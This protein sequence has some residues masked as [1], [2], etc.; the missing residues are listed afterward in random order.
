VIPHEYIPGVEKGVQSVWDSGELIGFPFFDTR[1]TL[2]DG[3]YH[4][5]DSSAFAFETAAREAM[6]DDVVRASLKIMEPIM[7]VEVL[8]PTDFVGSVVADLN[9]R[10]SHI[11]GQARRCEPTPPC[12]A[13]M[14]RWLGCLATKGT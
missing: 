4:D 1:V 8:S 9:N 6:R 13:P 5:M 14:R 2:F 7:D 12:S 11:R 3:A 10:R